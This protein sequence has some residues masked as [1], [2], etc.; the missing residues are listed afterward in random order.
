MIIREHLQL[1]RIA[2]IESGEKDEIIED[3]ATSID[4]AN[5]SIG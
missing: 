4:V 5:H 3:T 1:K 2:E